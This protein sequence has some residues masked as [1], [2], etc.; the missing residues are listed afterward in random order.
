MR[1]LRDTFG[2]QFRELIE[3][4]IMAYNLYGW[5]RNYSPTNTVGALTRVEPV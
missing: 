3:V 1:V 2:Y 5:S 4:K